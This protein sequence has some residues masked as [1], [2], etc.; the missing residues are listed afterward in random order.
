MRLSV[1][2]MAKICLIEIEASIS[3]CVTG[4]ITQLRSRP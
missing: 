4:K 2:R 3:L 1:T